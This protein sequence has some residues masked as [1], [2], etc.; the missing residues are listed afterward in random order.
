ML[1]TGLSYQ[2]VEDNVNDILFSHLCLAGVFCLTSPFRLIAP[3]SIAA[4]RPLALGRV[5]KLMESLF[6]TLPG[7]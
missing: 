7:S 2:I 1:E 5:V 6:T 4:W 3:N